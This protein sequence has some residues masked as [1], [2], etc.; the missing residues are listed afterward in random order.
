MDCVDSNY[1]HSGAPIWK[2]IPTGM[3]YQVEPFLFQVD[4]KLFKFYGN[5]SNCKSN[6]MKQKF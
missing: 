4:N 3:P 5:Q 1:Q 6:N 2:R